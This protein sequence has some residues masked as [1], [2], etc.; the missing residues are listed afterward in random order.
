M[1]TEPLPAGKVVVRMQF[2]ADETKPG[3][4]GTASLWANGTK[5]GEGRIE[6]TVP[7]ALPAPPVS[8]RAQRVSAF[9]AARDGF[10]AVRDE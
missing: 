4:G 5:I 6:R 3:T 8:A 10:H 7:I 1:A 9:H 2:D